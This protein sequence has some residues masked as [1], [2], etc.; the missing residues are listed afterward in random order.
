M[1][2]VIT[3]RDIL[4]HPV[5][6]IRCFGWAMF[7]KALFA[8][9]GQTF[10]SLLPQV[11]PGEGPPT[12]LSMLVE[13]CILLELRAKRIYHTFALAFADRPDASEF[14]ETL[15]RHEQE[16]AELLA[17][18][19]MAAGHGGRIAD[20]FSPWL[21]YIPRLEEHMQSVEATLDEVG[22]LEDAL[23]LVIQIESS[24]I[25]RVFQSVLTSS[26]STFVERMDAF[27]NAIEKHISYI[28]G[29][30]PELDARFTLAAEEML[31][32]LPHADSEE[33]EPCAVG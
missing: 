11:A 8:G 4:R 10:L 19:G 15:A 13:R 12:K 31:G 23:G 21:S 6:T 16:H 26:N 24:E 30:L 32:M 3:H 22:V 20:A 27:R 28:A 14:F 33:L 1:I 9:Q 2:G 29:R 17:L 5:I 7:F 25:N 18:C